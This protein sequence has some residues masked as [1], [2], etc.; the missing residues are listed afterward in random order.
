MNPESSLYDQRQTRLQ[1]A[2]DV[3]FGKDLNASFGQGADQ[4]GKV[5]GETSQLS[6]FEAGD[7]PMMMDM[8]FADDWAMPTPPPGPVAQENKSTRHVVIDVSKLVD[9]TIERLRFHREQKA[10]QLC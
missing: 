2:S 1:N 5:L 8:S 9:G 4:F 7:D 6:G 3:L 10:N